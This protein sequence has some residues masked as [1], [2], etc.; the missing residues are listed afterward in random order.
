MSNEENEKDK[1]Q[2][3]PNL[4]DNSPTKQKQIEIIDKVYED[5]I[6]L[7]PNIELIDLNCFLKKYPYFSKKIIIYLIKNTYKNASIFSE[8][9]KNELKQIINKILSNLKK[10]RSLKIYSTFIQNQSLLNTIN[11]TIDVK[12]MNLCLKKGPYTHWWNILPLDIKKK[13]ILH[14]KV[15]FFQSG[16]TKFQMIVEEIN[17]KNNRKRKS[18]KILIND[19]KYFQRLTTLEESQEKT[20]VVIMDLITMVEE[21]EKKISQLQNTLQEKKIEN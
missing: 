6:N 9:K 1:V 4:C 10:F 12:L 18:K 3:R 2:E 15:L 20:N 8:D 21:L 17:T 5:L 16:H 13:F 7:Y 19:T 14:S 11:E